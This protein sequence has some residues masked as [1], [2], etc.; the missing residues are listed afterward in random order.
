MD[1]LKRQRHPK[2][3]ITTPKLHN[4]QS[5]TPYSQSIDRTIDRSIDRTI[6]RPIDRTINKSINQ[7]AK[8][9]GFRALGLKFRVYRRN[10]RTSDRSTNPSSDRTLNLVCADLEARVMGEQ[11]DETLNLPQTPKAWTRNNDPQVPIWKLEVWEDGATWKDGAVID[12]DA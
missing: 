5:I 9:L 2:S 4:C 1:P 3:H 7:L 12:P 10:E 6:D 8:G 11:R